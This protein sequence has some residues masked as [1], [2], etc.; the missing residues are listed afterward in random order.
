MNITSLLFVL[1][2]MFLS[3][4]IANATVYDYDFVREKSMHS[5]IEHCQYINQEHNYTVDVYNDC[6]RKYT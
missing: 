3:V 5:L 4:N 6:S 1:V 2:A